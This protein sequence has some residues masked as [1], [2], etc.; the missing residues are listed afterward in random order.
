MNPIVRS[1]YVCH[2]FVQERFFWLRLSKNVDFAFLF[3]A[4]CFGGKGLSLNFIIYVPILMRVKE[5]Y[6]N[7]GIGTNWI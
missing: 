2:L 4:N 1:K 3:F 6:M 5:N 7:Y